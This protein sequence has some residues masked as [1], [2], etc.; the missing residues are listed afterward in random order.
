MAIVAL[1]VLENDSEVPGVEAPENPIVEH[2][3]LPVGPS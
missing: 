1:V 2:P 3:M